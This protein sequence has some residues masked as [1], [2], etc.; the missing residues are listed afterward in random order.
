MGRRSHVSESRRGTAKPRDA[1]VGSGGLNELELQSNV[2]LFADHDSAGFQRGIEGQA[3]LPAVDGGGGSDADARVAP[4]VLDRR[5]GTFDGKL[6]LAGD[7]VNAE[8]PCD[9]NAAIGTPRDTG[10][11]E[12]E[13]RELLDVEEVRT[14]EVGVALGVAGVDGGGIDGSFDTGPGGVGSIVGELAGNAGKAAADVGDHHVADA[15]LGGGV[16]GVDGPGGDGGCSGGGTHACV[17]SLRLD[18]GQGYS[19]QQISV[20]N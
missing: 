9:E 13:G 3:K 11:A 17:S 20:K 16:D 18:E 14:L 5:G 7:A 4:R 1:A 2:N 6:Y 19:L 12:G 10:R 15:E 8:R